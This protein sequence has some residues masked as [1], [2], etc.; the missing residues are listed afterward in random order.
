MTDGTRASDLTPVYFSSSRLGQGDPKDKFV[1]RRYLPGQY[2]YIPREHN[3]DIVMITIYWPPGNLNLYRK[4]LFARWR[5]GWKPVLVGVNEE[6]VSPPCDMDFSFSYNP[7][8][9]KNC[10]W[11][12]P[13]NPSYMAYVLEGK[14]SEEIE[15]LIKTPKTRFCN[16][17]YSDDF[18]KFTKV[19]QDFCKLLAQYKKVDCPGPALNNMPPIPEEAYKKSWPAKLDFLANYK[20]TIAFEH[21]SA[22][23]Y[24]TEKIWHAF[25]T[26]SIPIYWGC[27]QVAEYFNPKAF[28]NCHDYKTFED[29]MERVKEIDNSPRLY[30]EYRNA[31]IVFQNSRLHVVSQDITD[32][33]HAITKE[34]LL[35]RNAR[36]IKYWKM[37]RMILFLCS[38]WKMTARWIYTRLKE[39][40][41]Q[42]KQKDIASPT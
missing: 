1:P 9:G 26:G 15:K 39:R 20:F 2:E 24:L 28:I 4:I 6:H 5:F 40:L 23:N 35:R 18:K 3:P 13:L 38:H 17:V 33:C 14:R 8:D 22:E 36:G 32:H 10:A 27:P 34:A 25:F 31:P 11:I 19:R 41:L 30:E 7:T 12:M 21:T 42:R 29:A 16:F 37:P